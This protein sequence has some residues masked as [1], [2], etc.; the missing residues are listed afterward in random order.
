LTDGYDSVIGE[1]GST[2]SGG[3]RQRIAIARAI[4]KDPAI[5]IMDEAMSQI[6]SESE[7][8]IHR[9]L[10][11]FTEGRTT[12]VI[13]HRFSTVVSADTVVVMHD[14]KVVDVGGHDELVERCDVYRTLFETQ[15]I[16]DG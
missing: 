6:D 5:L 14:G 10:Q 2:L 13:A 3:Q 4:L 15:L 9:A 7:A 11:T 1:H 8:K 12:L 16:G